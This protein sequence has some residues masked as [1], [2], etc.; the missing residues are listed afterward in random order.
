MNNLKK[1][2]T[3]IEAIEENLILR[4]F[5]SEA[6]W[7]KELKKYWE[8]CKKYPPDYY[9]QAEISYNRLPP[10]HAK[11]WSAYYEK[12]HRKTGYVNVN[13]L[14]ASD[15][16]GCF[17]CLSI[18]NP[19]HLHKWLHENIDDPGI[20]CC[21][22]CGMDSIL[23]SNMGYPVTKTFLANLHWW[24]L[25]TIRP[26]NQSERKRRFVYQA[27]RCHTESGKMQKQ[28]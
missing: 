7:K 18:F 20:I 24:S 13:D 11:S 25:G 19:H 27:K 22:F 17:Y 9:E 14:M 26:D 21:P 10:A 6:K 12:V 3:R 4:I 15:R 23:T 8:D 16:A 5:G 1:K 28:M 2:S